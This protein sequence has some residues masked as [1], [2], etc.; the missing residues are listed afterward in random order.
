MR[1]PKRRWRLLAPVAMVLVVVALLSLSPSA[2]ATPIQKQAQQT[3]PPQKSAAGECV[4]EDLIFT[5]NFR[6]GSAWADVTITDV[7]DDRLR[8]DEVTV[9]CQ[10]GPCPAGTTVSGPGVN[11]VVVFIP[12]LPANSTVT[13]TVRCWCPPDVTPVTFVNTATVV[14]TDPTGTWT[15]TTSAD[16]R[17]IDCFVPEAGSLLLLGSGLAGLAGYAGL[18][19]RV[20]RE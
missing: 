18:R 17:V 7:I 9:E 2:W 20:R 10:P 6:N 5:V 19:W 8:I 4:G 13:I 12:N 11:P 14:F 3:V 1:E 15:Y 16:V